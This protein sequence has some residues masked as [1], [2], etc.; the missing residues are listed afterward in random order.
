M[1]KI[2]FSLLTRPTALTLCG[3]D[4]L[5]LTMGKVAARPVT[6]PLLQPHLAEDSLNRKRREEFNIKHSS[7]TK[8]SEIKNL[9]IVH[10]FYSAAQFIALGTVS[11][12][13]F[14]IRSHIMLN[15]C[16]SGLN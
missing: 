11:E 14:W 8:P 10:P 5:L 15:Q 9:Q 3:L 6:L 2:Q 13:V 4:E 7:Q 1:D 16:M 12:A